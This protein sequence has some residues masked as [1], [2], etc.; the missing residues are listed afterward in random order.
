MELDSE[1]KRS[2]GFQEYL[3]ISFIAIAF[4]GVYWIFTAVISLWNAPESV[5]FISFFIN[6]LETNGV[7]IIAGPGGEINWP[8]KW[9]VIVGVFLTIVLISSIG[10]LT[11]TF[12][13]AGL[14][15]LFPK[16]HFYGG[17]METLIYRVR[18]KDK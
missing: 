9:Q 16:I 6:Q 2:W 17:L 18:G 12:L 8:E 15:L 3:G 1:Q 7:T 5:P 4:C 10:L 13:V 14:C 11:K